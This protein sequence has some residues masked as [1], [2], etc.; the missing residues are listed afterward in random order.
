MKVWAHVVRDLL[1][2]L[3]AIYDGV[4]IER[5]ELPNVDV[6]V[7]KLVLD[8][9]KYVLRDIV[10]LL[11]IRKLRWSSILAVHFSDTQI[12]SLTRLLLTALEPKVLR[13][14]E[15]AGFAASLAIV[16]L[17]IRALLWILVVRLLLAHSFGRFGGLVVVIIHL[18]IT[19]TLRFSI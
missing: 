18:V 3:T 1:V 14:C 9:L 15:E 4:W 6:R 16:L 11:I 8:V 10:V 13:S 12:G 19:L 17:V 5:A 7:S 2:T